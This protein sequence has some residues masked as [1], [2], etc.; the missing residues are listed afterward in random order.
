MSQSQTPDFFEYTL[1][2]IDAEYEA[3]VRAAKERR[4][5]RI[6]QAHEWLRSMGNPAA[7]PTT[8]PKEDEI[9]S[10]AESV[11]VHA[12]LGN[13]AAANG[14]GGSVVLK[15]IVPRFVN[16][17]MVD[18]TVNIVTQTDI[19]DRIL[20][21]YAVPDDSVNSLRVTITT[22]LNELVE[23]GYLEL[24]EKAKAGRPNKY[25]KTGKLF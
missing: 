18:P 16:E 21:H 12:P 1:R 25:R 23:Q 9:P 24:V 11:N 17:V 2:G 15:D 7:Y 20:A 19:K 13:G 5:K 4:D 14:S 22:H 6:A 8:T 10:S 3:D